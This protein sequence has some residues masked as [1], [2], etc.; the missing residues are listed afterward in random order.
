M[1]GDERVESA[2]RQ[3]RRRDTLIVT[4]AFLAWGGLAASVIVD[5]GGV[6]AS[7]DVLVPLLLAAVL[8][9]SI[10][11]RSRLRRFAVGVAV[12]WLPFVLALWLYDLI[13]GVADGLW[14][15]VHYGRQ[16]DFDRFIGFGTV[17]SVWLQQHLW[18]GSAHV[19]WYDYAS[20]LVYMSYFFGTTIVLVLLWW[21]SRGLFWRFAA[22]V[23]GLAFLG[24]LTFVLYPAEPP[25]MAA[26][27][28]LMPPLDRIIQVMNGHLPGVSLQPLW[29]KG[30][31]YA[32]DVAAMPSLHASY[33]L[34]IALFFFRRLHRR[35]RH[36]LW[37]YPLA[38]AFALVY[39]GEHY[40]V[41]VVAGWIYCVAVYFTVEWVAAR[42]ARATLRRLAPQ[43]LGPALGVR[44]AT[45]ASEDRTV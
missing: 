13:R 25:W 10:T 44:S 36:L 14:L 29:E 28:G 41:D 33:T 2:G 26:D 3:N 19:E 24:C 40:V 7:R 4:L 34:L 30:T 43:Q 21:R 6:P 23:V 15:P 12:D 18:H 37:L 39:T 35:S 20:W 31:G 9:A 42:P 32:N 22:S 5:E 11:S 17:P 27:Q 8:A 45:L 38:M 16:I 1:V